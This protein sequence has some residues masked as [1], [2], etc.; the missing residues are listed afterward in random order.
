MNSCE[1]TDIPRRTARFCGD[2]EAVRVFV[3]S[4]KWIFSILLKR[5][6]RVAPVPSAVAPGQL[7]ISRLMTYFDPALPRSV[8]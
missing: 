4:N 6:H 7:P 1:A 5:G 3:R 8:L 2:S